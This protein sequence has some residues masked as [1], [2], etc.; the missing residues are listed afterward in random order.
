[1]TDRG[2]P[3]PESR[4]ADA[5]PVEALLFDFGGVLIDIDFD[6]VCAR[7]AEHAGCA[8]ASIKARFKPDGHYERHERGEIDAAAY[9]ASLRSSLGV[10]LTDA[11]FDDG[12]QAVFV[13]EIGGMAALLRRA[14]ATLPLYVFSNTNAAHYAEWSRRYREVLRPFQRVFVSC[15]IGKRKPDA[16]AFR[17][18]AAAMAVPL[19]RILFFDDS[20]E[21]VEGARLSGM[22]AVHV[23]SIADVEAALETVI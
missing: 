15:E 11:Q 13:A 14:G 1:M 2:I 20:L 22:R 17:A 12:W 9:F 3:N 6:R 23:R 4:I 21:N 5:A 18:V 8:A 19:P 7:W 10:D 16:D